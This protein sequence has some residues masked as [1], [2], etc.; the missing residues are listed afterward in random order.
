MYRRRGLATRGM[1]ALSRRILRNHGAVVL[2]VSSANQAA[3]RLYKRMGYRTI[4][5]YQAV[6]FHPPEPTSLRVPAP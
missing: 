6:Y 4:G 1:L 2:F 3:M 5:K